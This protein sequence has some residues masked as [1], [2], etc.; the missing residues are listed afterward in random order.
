MLGNRLYSPYGT[1]LYQ[2]ENVGTTKDFVLGHEVMFRAV[3]MA[4]KW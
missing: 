3:V 4:P 2:Q 1:L